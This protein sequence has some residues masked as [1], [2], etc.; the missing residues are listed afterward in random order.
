MKSILVE[1]HTDCG[2]VKAAWHGN[3]EGNLK[4]W[5]SYIRKNL[6]EK[7][8]INKLT[9]D[10]LAKI[11]VLKQVENLKDHPIYKTY[12][13][14]VEIIGSLFHVASGELELLNRGG[15]ELLN[16]LL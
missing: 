5:L 4:T 14:G 9:E 12:G 3:G 10:N 15:D 13:Q 2:G 16:K 1:G 7:D 8:G 11:N 6:P